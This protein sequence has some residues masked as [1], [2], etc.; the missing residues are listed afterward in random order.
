MS[1]MMAIYDLATKSETLKH[2]T[3]TQTRELY[4]AVES[5]AEGWDGE[6][7]SPEY[8]VECMERRYRAVGL[9][10]SRN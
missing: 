7:V 2:L 9:I 5:E 1:R 10:P 6:Y 8:V 3:P 4:D